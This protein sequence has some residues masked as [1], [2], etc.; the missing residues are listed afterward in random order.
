MAKKRKA[1][2][3]V[4]QPLTEKPKRYSF[5]FVNIPED[6]DNVGTSKKNMV[7][8]LP[9]LVGADIVEV[10][11]SQPICPQ[12]EVLGILAGTNDEVLLILHL[13]LM[14]GFTWM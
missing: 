12:T 14:Y 13:P 8:A 7:K 2:E 4:A 5:Q 3:S 6:Q 9:D 10:Q 11:D 1:T